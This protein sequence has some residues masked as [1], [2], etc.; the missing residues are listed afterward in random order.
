MS[1][2]LKLSDEHIID[3]TWTE[4]DTFVAEWVRTPHRWYWEHDVAAELAVR[5]SRRLEK[6]GLLLSPQW[7][8]LDGKNCTCRQA[9]RVHVD[10]SINDSGG[11][12]RR[13]DIVIVADNPD[14]TC[15]WICEVKCGYP[16][17]GTASKTDRDQVLKDIRKGLTHAGC[18]LNLFIP[19]PRKS[20]P[21]KWKA[22]TVS[23]SFREYSVEAASPSR[24]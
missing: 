11:K 19:G 10:W 14:A 17:G 7:D 24:N 9:R 15:L 3:A 6:G 23:G 13:G 21:S 12:R 20:P 1:D 18:I 22:P 16:T 4:L 2:R 5:I 8:D